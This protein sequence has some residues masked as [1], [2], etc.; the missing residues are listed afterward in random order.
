MS[1]EDQHVPSNK[2]RDLDE[3]AMKSSSSRGLIAPNSFHIWITASTGLIS[4][5]HS[6]TQSSVSSS[7]P[8]LLFIYSYIVKKTHKHQ[9]SQHPA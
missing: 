3:S 5:R 2:Y 6:Y 7:T 8:A 4:K 9:F 1:F